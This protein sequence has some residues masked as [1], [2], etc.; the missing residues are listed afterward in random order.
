MYVYPKF[1]I[2]IYIYIHTHAHAYKTSLIRVDRT[3][4]NNF[5]SKYFGNRKLLLKT[6]AE[7]R[8]YILKLDFYIYIRVYLCRPIR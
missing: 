6:K 3:F 4:S 8:L 5:V 1:N 2:Y 7:C